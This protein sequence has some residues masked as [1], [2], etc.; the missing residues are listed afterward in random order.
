MEW[1]INPREEAHVILLREEH[2]RRFSEVAYL[3]SVRRLD[4]RGIIDTER[5]SP[6]IE[7]VAYLVFKLANRCNGLESAKS[8]IKF[9]N[10]ESEI[11]TQ[12]QA[13]TVHLARLQGSGDIPKMR[14][15]GWMKVKLGYFNSKKSTNGPVEA[16]L[17][18]KKCIYKGGLIVKGIEFR[19][20]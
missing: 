11:D 3:A 14:G 7:Y 20:K 19:L 6:K 13:N 10:Y 1:D 4:I 18:K 5:L 16:R 15:D 2:L 12:N 17:I 8:S 9:V